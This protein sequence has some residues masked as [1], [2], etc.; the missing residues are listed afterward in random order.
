[1]SEEYSPQVPSAA[2]SRASSW[3]YLILL[4]TATYALAM[5]TAGAFPAPLVAALRP[6]LWSVTALFVIDLGVQLRRAH[7]GGKETLRAYL[8]SWFIVDAL[9]ALPLSFTPGLAIGPGAL[10]LLK[11]SGV[12][13]AMRR[14]RLNS[15][16][17]ASPLP[18]LFAVFW[19]V[20][21]V[22]WI[23]T[24]WLVLRGFDPELTG[25]ANYIDSMYWTVT[26]LTSVGYGDITPTGSVQKLYAMGTMVVGLAFLGYMIGIMA[27]MLSRRDPARVLLQENIERL[28]VATQYGGIPRELQRRVFDYYIYLWRQR[29]GYNE[30][31]FLSSLPQGLQEEVSR[32][33]KGH[34]LER[35]DLF[36]GADPDLVGQVALQLRPEILTPGDFVFREGDGGSSMYFIAGGELAVLRDGREGAVTVLRRGDFF[37]EIALFSNQPRSASIQALTYCDVYSLSKADFDRIFRRFPDTLA[38]IEQKAL[39]RRQRDASGQ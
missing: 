15:L 5:P 25:I 23:C 20:V 14:W 33:L 11:L 34:V 12:G 29:L 32:H 1:M 30:S 35:I 10:G 24:G 3:T 7:M 31:D 38:E 27:S 19:L 21:V 39:S 17:Y 36:R 37:G 22:H 6:L 18:L 8:G 16:R 4:A 28:S 13:R 2:G 9:A 26:T